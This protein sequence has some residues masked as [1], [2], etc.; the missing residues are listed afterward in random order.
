MTKKI[1]VVDDDKLFREGLTSAL[2]TAAHEVAEAED[3]ETGLDKALKLQ[4]DLIITDL[5]MPHLDGLGMVAKLRKDDWGK[6]VPVIV[7]TDDEKTTSINEAL[8][9]GVTI[10][11]SKTTLDPQSLNEQVLIALG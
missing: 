10:Y 3:G 11:L 6:N 4:P 1:L 8:Q 5:R 7:L 9:A 2:R